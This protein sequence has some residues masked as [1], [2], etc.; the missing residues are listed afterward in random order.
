VTASAS[1]G[2]GA[3]GAVVG[4]GVGGQPEADVT[5]GTTP[6]LGDAPPSSGTGI[7][8]G[9]SLLQPPPTVPILPG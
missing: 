4:L 7:G 5:V 9:G 6:V 2:E 3:G 1:A 8:L